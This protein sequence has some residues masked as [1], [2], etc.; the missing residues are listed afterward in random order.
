MIS[1]KITNLVREKSDKRNGFFYGWIIAA[2]C[3]AMVFISLGL[4]NLPSAMY[5]TPVTEDLGFSRGAFSIVF[6]LRLITMAAFSI[7]F[8]FF[9][10]K[11]EIRRVIGLGFGLITLSYFMFSVA[12]NLPVFYMGGIPFGIG[13]TFSSTAVVSVLVE[14]W[15]VK[16]KGMLLGVIFA[17][18]GL[19]GSLFNIIVSGW[20]ENYGWSK[21]YFLTAICLGI[22]AIP[23]LA[24]IRNNPCEMGLAPYGSEGKEQLEKKNKS[25]NWEGFTFE[26][27]LKKP[28]FYIAAVGIFFIGFLNSP[29]YTAAPSYLMDKGFDTKFSAAIMSIFFFTLAVAKVIMG[30]IYDRLGL[31]AALIICFGSNICGTLLLA[32]AQNKFIALLFAIFF[33]F[34]VPIET[35][36]Q[37]L[38]VFELFGSKTY[39]A[40]IGIFLAIST[41]GVSIGTPIMN[42]S[43]DL[44]GSYQGMLIIFA[45]ISVVVL[46][47][48][49]YIMNCAQ[50]DQ[51]EYLNLKSDGK[52]QAM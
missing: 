45:A 39:T 2:A 3:F 49:I 38:L 30:L 5:I 16:H 46:A 35:V 32:F 44:T 34:S 11:L 36:T 10:R 50:K 19:G 51:N 40:A 9:V 29:V 48:F 18:S 23:V 47:L 20:I 4:G 27:S 17:G 13:I 43:Y 52:Y 42:Y 14:R 37:P 1:S 31:K 12:R 6:S 28:Y 21:S 24:I 8:G 15:F 26:E 33:G 22:F 25:V 41:M 7:F